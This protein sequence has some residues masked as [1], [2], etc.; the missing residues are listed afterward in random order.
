MSVETLG[1]TH[2]VKNWLQ[3]IAD[4]NRWVKVVASQLLSMLLVS[5]AFTAQCAAKLSLIKERNFS[6]GDGRGITLGDEIKDGRYKIQ[7]LLG[8]SNFSSVWLA[9]DSQ[10]RSKV[11][12]KVRAST[13]RQM[14]FIFLP[15]CVFHLSTPHLP[16]HFTQQC[17]SCAS[18][19]Q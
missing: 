19:Q 13:L 14:S 3:R 6:P 17:V 15:H 1:H 7:G 18:I 10:L 12:V 16:G 4:K 2:V 9:K 11:A 5:L 8:F